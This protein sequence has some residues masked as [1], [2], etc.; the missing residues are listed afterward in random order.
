[1]PSA[2]F[3]GTRRDVVVGLAFGFAGVGALAALRPLVEQMN[4][5]GSSPRDNVEVDLGMLDAGHLKL[6]QWK[7]QAIFIRWRAPDEIAISRGIS[8]ASLI[9]PSARVAGLS[10]RDIATDDNRTKAGH[11]EWL[12]VAGACTQCSCLLK[13]GRALSFDDIAFFC[14]CCASRFDLAGRTMGGPARTNLAVPSYRFIGR[15]R[16]EIGL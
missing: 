13:D 11:R 9:D 5:N 1:M 15:S 8:V 10:D 4:P 7:G 2:R 12:V 14:E 16:L 6:T 3:S